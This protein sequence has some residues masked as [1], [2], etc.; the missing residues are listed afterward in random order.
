MMIGNNIPN[1]PLLR[2]RFGNIVVVANWNSDRAIFCKSP[3]LST[4]SSQ[5]NFYDLSVSANLQ[6]WNSVGIAFEYIEAFSASRILPSFGPENSHTLVTVFGTGFFASSSF[7]CKTGIHESKPI[8]VISSVLLVCIVPPSP[9]G[10]MSLFA[11]ANSLDYQSLGLNFLHYKNPMLLSLTPS[12][13]PSCGGTFVLFQGTNLLGSTLFAKFGNSVVIC[14]VKDS[15]SAACVTPSHSPGL[16]PVEISLNNVAFTANEVPFMYEDSIRITSIFPTLGPSEIG[17]TKVKVSLGSPVSVSSQSRCSFGGKLVVARQL[18]SNTI[19]CPAPPAASGAVALE[20][21]LNGVD[22][23]SSGQSFL[24]HKLVSVMNISVSTSLSAGNVPVFILGSQ[25]SDTEGILCRFG[26]QSISAKFLTS[27]SILCFTPPH[28]VGRVN[29]EISLNSMDYS[30]SKM[31]F[32]YEDCPPS[33]FCLD[34]DTILCPKGSFCP[35]NGIS[36]FTMCPPGTY[37]F[38]AGR[39]TCDRCPLGFTCPD[40]GMVTAVPCPSGMVCDTPGLSIARK[41][42]P[43]GHYCLSGTQT[44]DPN[45]LSHLRPIPCPEGYY[46]SYG[47][48]SNVSI[49]MNFSTPQPCTPGYFCSRGSETPHGQGPCPSGFSC[50]LSYP[51]VAQA[52]PA[53]TFCPNT[54]NVEPKNC[55]PGSFNNQ[56]AQSLCQLCPVGAM[57]PDYGLRAPSTCPEGY[58]CDQTGRPSWSRQCPPGY[59]CQ[60]GTKTAD[61][62]SSI[63]PR[64]NPCSPGTYCTIG[65]RTDATTV[66]DMSTPQPCNEGTYCELATPTPTG[67]ASCPPGYFC[68]AGQSAPKIVEAGYFSRREG[69]VIPSPC[70]PGSFSVIA[71]SAV[72]SPCPAGHNCANE[73]ITQPSLCPPGFFRSTCSGPGCTSSLSCQAC[74]Q[75]TISSLRALPD[76]SLCDVCP[77]G[78]VC[79]K[80]SMLSIADASPCPEGHV[81]GIGTTSDIQFKTKCPAGFVCD[82]GTSF[83]NQFSIKCRAGFACPEGTGMSQAN[84]LVCMGGFYC[85]E[86]SVSEKAFRCPLGT[87]SENNAKSVLECKQDTKSSS[88]GVICRVNAIKNSQ[89]NYD[90]CLASLKCAKESGDNYRECMANDRRISE[91][92]ISKIVNPNFPLSKIEKYFIFLPAMTLTTFSFNWTLVPKELMYSQHFRLTLSMSGHPNHPSVVG[93]HPDF[94]VPYTQR[95]VVSEREKYEDMTNPGK[96]SQDS[97]SGGSPRLSGTEHDLNTWFGKSVTPDASANNSVVFPIQNILKFSVFPPLDVWIRWDVEMIHGQ[98]VENKNYTSFFNTMTYVRTQPMRADTQESSVPKFFVTLI[99]KEQNEVWPPLNGNNFRRRLI[100]TTRDAPCGDDVKN[101]VQHQGTAV[102]HSPWPWV[103]FVSSSVC[104]NPPCNEQDN[105]PKETKLQYQESKDILATSYGIGS[106]DLANYWYTPQDLSGA[107]GFDGVHDIFP[108]LPYFSSCRGYDS[109]IPFFQVTEG[110]VGCTSLPAPENTLWINEWAPFANT[111]KR[112]LQQKTDNCITKLQCLYEE[113]FEKQYEP[114]PWYAQDPGSKIFYFLG[115]PVSVL[116]WKKSLYGTCSNNF[117]SDDERKKLFDVLSSRRGVGVTVG[118]L[119]AGISDSFRTGQKGVPRL[120]TLRVKYYQESPYKKRIV[121]ADITYDDHT[122]WKSSIGVENRNYTLVVVYEAMGWVELLNNFAF[123]NGLFLAVFVAVG[124]VNLIFIALFWAQIRLFSVLKDPPS[125]NFMEYI[126]LSAYPRF[127][128]FAIAISCILFCI[129]IMVVVFG[130]DSSMEPGNGIFDYAPPD[131]D[132]RFRDELEFGDDGNRETREKIIRGRFSSCVFFL[133]FFIALTSTR[134]VIIKRSDRASQ[135][136]L[137]DAG[138]DE[139]QHEAQLEEETYAIESKRTHEM[140]AILMSVCCCTILWEFSYSEFYEENVYTVLVFG[141]MLNM[142]V[143]SWNESFLEESVLNIP[144]TTIVTFVGNINGLG[145]SSFLDFLQ[146]FLV[147]MAISTTQRIFID[148]ALDTIIQGVSSIMISILNL[149]TGTVADESESRVVEEEDTEVVPDIV[150]RYVGAS[151]DAITGLASPILILSVQLLDPFLK[152]GSEYNILQADFAFYNLFA[153]VMIGVRTVTDILLNNVTEMFYGDKL[154]E[155]L[156]FCRH[157]YMYRTHRW[158][159]M[160]DGDQQMGRDLRGLD[161]FGFSSQFYFFVSLQAFGGI[162]MCFGVQGI[163]RATYNPFG[164]KV[165][166]LLGF[167]FTIYFW[168]ITKLLKFL[169]GKYAWTLNNQTEIGDEGIATSSNDGDSLYIPDLTAALEGYSGIN[170][171]QFQPHAKNTQNVSMPSAILSSESFKHQF[172]ENNKPWILRQLGINE[173]SSEFQTPQINIEFQNTEET[174]WDQGKRMQMVLARGDI[175]DDSSDEDAVAL[176][177]RVRKIMS[178]QIGKMSPVCR[179]LLFR[180]LGRTRRRLGIPDLLVVADNITD[181][182]SSAD[183]QAKHLE[184]QEI[185]IKAQAI[186]RFW[187]TLIT[188]QG[189]KTDMAIELAVPVS[190]DSGSDDHIN[191]DYDRLITNHVKGIAILWLQQMRQDQNGGGVRRVKNIVSDES[192]LSEESDEFDINSAPT[193]ERAAVRTAPVSSDTGDDTGS[194]LTAA[195]GTTSSHGRDDRVP[196]QIQFQTQADGP[197]LT[198]R[199]TARS[200]SRASEGAEFQEDSAAEQDAPASSE[201][202]AQQDTAVPILPK[203]RRIARMWLDMMNDALSSRRSSN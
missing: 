173:Y 186:A 94:G 149:A 172:L 109:H 175:T 122:E 135:N 20:F 56:P 125:L 190:D 165:F 51:G 174:P 110:G 151:C 21:S 55:E 159:Y 128:G 193:F 152:I 130:I 201:P 19:E 132:A 42:C 146:A 178:K 7:R 15:L 199:S 61:P 41:P 13:G 46:C 198:A 57:C 32:Q 72:C 6:D 70:P 53:G 200:T 23:T 1:T 127:I 44:A 37:Q 24:F 183:E 169:G 68:P 48:V 98:F 137:N 75:G 33:F 10:E 181:E 191:A 147:D 118:P 148:P 76:E 30:N 40:F 99:S 29:L 129:P 73:A 97:S 145:C 162:F 9:A 89:D 182:D 189:E 102:E 187:R 142:V 80:Q 166:P 138:V 86:G 161:L 83:E 179:L 107:V 88:I 194:S 14:D 2:C 27:D 39:S 38:Q 202:V 4:S 79:S 52:C 120:V 85:P 203:T 108:Y 123:S 105:K 64:P 195:G 196:A 82:F 185:S 180:W 116:E 153:V 164:D 177:T 59:W 160:G 16:V 71:G 17:V 171:N 131:F 124:A 176:R 77:S 60:Q 158:I 66:G 150:G 112:V 143:E 36:N 155:Y 184:P 121:T 58:V 31:Q 134:F 81:C 93:T 140:F 114:R 154:L 126:R 139:K 113:D 101:K 170:Q 119:P 167:L 69:A 49:A 28:P 92:D 65:V 63:T 104:L 197:A 12:S 43:P 156:R 62:D 136:S 25:F 96:Q 18:A 168:G 67:T 34:D 47:A 8:Q 111:N 74:P 3:S 157:R 141:T 188:K 95:F 54:G 11:S 90:D 115:D 91:F 117:G 35:G 78:I 106:V 192:D 100:D 103:N 84:R 133:G 144:I 163:L 45:A 87:T 22:F 5:D 50:S 26:S